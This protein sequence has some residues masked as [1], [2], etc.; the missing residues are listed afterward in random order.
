MKTRERLQVGEERG[1][2]RRRRE[3]TGQITP[4]FDKASRSHIILYLVEM[5]HKT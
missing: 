5:I 4:M 2:Y 1:Q 3:E